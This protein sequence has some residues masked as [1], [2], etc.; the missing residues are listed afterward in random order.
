MGKSGYI[1][2]GLLDNKTRIVADTHCF[3]VQERVKTKDGDIWAGKY[4]YSQLGD[5][6][7]GFIKHKARS[8]RKKVI[9]SKPL[10]D[11]I[12]LIA[13]LEKTVKEVGER[14]EKQFEVI[15]SDPVEKSIKEGKHA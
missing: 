1:L 14:L 15:R 6:I 10:L 11:L 2:L 3:I 4:F 9:S 13:S 8:S 7:R 12:D 5:A